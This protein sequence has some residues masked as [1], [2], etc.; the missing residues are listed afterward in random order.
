VTQR[1][2]GW[3][4]TPE[5]FGAMKRRDRIKYREDIETKKILIMVRRLAEQ[6]ISRGNFSDAS[7]LREHALGVC[8]E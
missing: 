8:G 3:G 6:L 2:P 4:G 5:R 1:Q 7:M